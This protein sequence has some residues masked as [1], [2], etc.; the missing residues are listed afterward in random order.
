MKLPDAVAQLVVAAD[1]VMKLPVVHEL[2]VAVVYVPWF[3]APMVTESP[4]VFTYPV[5]R[6]VGSVE[7]G[8]DTL[9]GVFAVA[10][11]VLRNEFESLPS[12]SA[13]E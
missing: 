6:L 13:T 12:R 11:K 5:T 2:T 1:V 3:R 4:E 8:I 7:T 9:M 10:L